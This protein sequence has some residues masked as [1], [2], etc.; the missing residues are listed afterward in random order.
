[1]G[2]IAIQ[3]EYR[4]ILMHIQEEEGNASPNTL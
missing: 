1:M 3:E 2:N 4:A